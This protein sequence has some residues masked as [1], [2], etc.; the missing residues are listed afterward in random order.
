MEITYVNQKE[1]AYLELRRQTS[2]PPAEC[3]RIPVEFT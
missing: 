2:D 3:H 1:M